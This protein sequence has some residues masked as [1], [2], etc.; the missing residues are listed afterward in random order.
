MSKTFKFYMEA[1]L[2]ALPEMVILIWYSVLGEVILVSSV[3][4]CFFYQQSSHKY[5]RKFHT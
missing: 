5:P 1:I 4:D 3:S 2:H